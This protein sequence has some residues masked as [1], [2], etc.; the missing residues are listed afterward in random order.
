MRRELAERMRLLA[1]EVE[2]LVLVAA[3]PRARR[4]R[5]RRCR[6]ARSAR[7][8]RRRPGR[9]RRRRGRTRAAGRRGTGSCAGTR[10]AAPLVA[11]HVAPSRQCDRAV[12]EGRRRRGVHDREVGE[13]ADADL[14][15][16]LDERLVRCDARSSTPSCTLTMNTRSPGQAPRAPTRGRG[17]RRTTTSAPGELRA[18]ARR[19]AR[20]GVCGTPAAASRRG[21]VAA[22]LAA[23]ARHHDTGL[24]GARHRRH[25]TGSTGPSSEAWRAN[26]TSAAMPAQGAASASAPVSPSVL[27]AA[28]PAD[29]PMAQRRRRSPSSSQA[30][31]SVVVPGSASS[32]TRPYDAANAGAIGMPAITMRPHMTGSDGATSGGTSAS[33]EQRRARPRSAMPRR[34]RRRARAD[35]EPADQ[36]ADAKHASAKP[37]CAREPCASPNAGISTSTTPNAVPSAKHATMTVRTAPDPSAPA[38]DGARAI[39]PAAR[40][41]GASANQ[42]VPTHGERGGRDDGRPGRARPRRPRPRSAGRR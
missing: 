38:R 31:A 18:H 33:R 37:P 14:R 12:G 20:A 6:R 36:R 29:V 41:G 21:D 40:T 32:P 1:G 42:S 23:R 15:G 2:R 3:A 24:I 19:P 35:P 7:R 39:R 27:D 11:D 16:R 13:Q 10:T 34:A 9:G 26:A 25:G 28:P 5:P 22:D 30:N 8:G 17:S 4:P